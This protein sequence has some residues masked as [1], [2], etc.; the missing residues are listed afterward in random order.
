MSGTRYKHLGKGSFFGELGYGRAVPDSHFSRH[1]D[2]VPLCEMNLCVIRY[3]PVI[4]CF[5]LA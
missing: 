3:A 1:V 5:A 4:G 2:R